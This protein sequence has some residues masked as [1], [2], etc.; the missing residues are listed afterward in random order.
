M[1]T[2]GGPDII[3]DGLVFGYDADDR[4]PR[5]Y[6]GEPTVNL[7]PTAIANN[8]WVNN[9]SW[10]LTSDDTSTK[11]P[12]IP[13]VDTTPLLIAKAV[14]TTAGGSVHFG[15]QTTSVSASTVYTISV[16][17]M[18]NRAGCS[19]PY[20]RT[21]VNNNSLGNFT[22][23]GSGSSSNWPVNKWIKISCTAT[24]QANENA[25]FL[26][27]YMGSVVGD[28]VRYIGYQVEEKSHSTPLVL[29][30][31]SATQSLIDLKKTTTIDVSNVSFNSTAHPI[32]DGTD[33]SISI[34]NP[35]T[36]NSQGFTIELVIK[37][38]SYSNSPMIIT[39]NSHGIDHHVRINSSGK[40]GMITI[41][42]AN[43][44]SR[45]HATTST[46]TTGEYHHIT[47]TYDSDTG[48][49]VYYNNDLEYSVAPDWVAKDWES[50]WIIGQRGNSTYFFNGSLPVLKVYNKVLGQ[51]EITQNFNAYKNRFNI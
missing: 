32:F 49:K 13:N 48:G 20:M 31:R 30:T 9:G 35:G 23:M 46:V 11:K 22:Y 39:P 2:S 42:A 8:N 4:S 18:Q 26:S 27:N 36:S 33:D 45:T 25:I 1:A 14:N 6:P 34:P 28:T 17:F 40:I 12:V 15:Y 21:G 5:F 37:P 41:L 3:T 47:F 29:G 50:T 24:T 10:V 19:S 38:N 44:S 51:A 16:Y 7:R 43:S